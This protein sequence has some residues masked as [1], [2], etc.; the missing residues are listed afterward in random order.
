MQNFNLIQNMNFDQFASKLPGIRFAQSTMPTSCRW[1]KSESVL[2]ILYFFSGRDVSGK[3]N[4][5][6]GSF[7]IR[8][9]RSLL[10]VIQEVVSCLLHKY[11]DVF[12]VF[13]K[14]RF[15]QTKEKFEKS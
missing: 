1:Y 9:V 4:T 8:L 10:S 11:K 14:I 12:I 13:C 15:F 3:A 5:V 2:T 6:S 7:E